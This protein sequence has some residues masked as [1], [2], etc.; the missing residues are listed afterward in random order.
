[1]SL[2]FFVTLRDLLKLSVLPKLLF[3]LMCRLESVLV[4]LKRTFTAVAERAVIYCKGP[5]DEPF[6]GEELTSLGK[7]FIILLPIWPAWICKLCDGSR[8]CAY[9]VRPHGARWDSAGG[10]L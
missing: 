9:I 3:L 4:I 6:W 7:Y 8:R 2:P 5:W 1:M 10:E